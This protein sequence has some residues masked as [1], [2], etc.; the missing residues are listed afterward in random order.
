MICLLILSADK[1]IKNQYWKI[2]VLVEYYKNTTLK[3]DNEK[4][5]LYLVA[6]KAMSC[7][8]YSRTLQCNAYI[9]T[10]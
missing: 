8:N 4:I 3:Y 9:G 2:F 7:F 10:S 5:L 1:V 6:I